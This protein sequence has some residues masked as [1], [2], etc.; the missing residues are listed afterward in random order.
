VAGPI[1]CWIPV[2]NRTQ[3]LFSGQRFSTFLL[4]QPSSIWLQLTLDAG[5]NAIK[6]QDF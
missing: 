2:S 6:A 1:A 3:A 5:G 4:L